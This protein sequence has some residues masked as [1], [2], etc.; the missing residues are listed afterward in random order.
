MKMMLFS[1]STNSGENY[2]AYTLPYFSK[3][4]DNK[5]AEAVFVPYAG[6][7][8]NWDDYSSKVAGVLNSVGIKILPL[9]QSK[10]EKQALENASIIMVGGGNTFHLL[11]TLQDKDLLD[12]IRKKVRTGTPYI[13]WSA[14]SNLACPTICTTNDMPIV[15]PHNF[16]AL[17]LI[18]FQINPHYTDAKLENHA[19]ET[20]EM[21]LEEYL[22]ANQET[23]VAGM[24][25]GTL[26]RLEKNALFLLG[27]KPCRVFRFGKTPKEL[28]QS[29]DFTFLI[30]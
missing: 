5:P 23:W 30:K 20:R 4:L 28:T 17:G 11:K 12:T 27:E 24:R 15:E 22:A 25:E 29:D 8:I 9:H 7:T 1:N 13:G 18:P 10:N 6:V 2:L 19:G 26:F 16:S 14:G 21:R 3:F